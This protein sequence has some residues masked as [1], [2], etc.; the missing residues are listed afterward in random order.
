[1]TRAR[2][3][4]IAIA[5]LSGAC[6]SGPALD[7]GDDFG[8][9]AGE[10][11]GGESGEGGGESGEGGSAGDDLDGAVAGNDDASAPDGEAGE[12]GDS[13]ATDAEPPAECTIDDECGALAPHCHDERCVE[14]LDATDCTN[15][16]RPV[17]SDGAC[18]ECEGDDCEEPSCEG[19]DCT[20]ACDGDEDCTEAERAHCSLSGQCVECTEDAQCA[21]ASE[22]GELHV[23]LIAEGH[24]E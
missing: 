20:T 2:I 22:P 4:A 5:L 23:C 15:E 3:L 19:E 11:G 12:G 10:G 24:C 21:E 17:C 18:I 13:G 8:P 16:E 6:S 14:C 9:E 1:M 7:L